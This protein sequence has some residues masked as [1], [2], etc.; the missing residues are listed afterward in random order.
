VLVRQFR[1]VLPRCPVGAQLIERFLSGPCL[2]FEKAQPAFGNAKP[3]RAIYIIAC[4]VGFFLHV[5]G[6]TPVFVLGSHD[7]IMRSIRKLGHSQIL[8]GTP[9]VKYGQ[10]PQ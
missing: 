2:W 1:F 5:T 8:I 9:R 10:S 4:P 3:R 7:E 6:V